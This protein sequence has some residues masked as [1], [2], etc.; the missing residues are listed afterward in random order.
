VLGN[1]GVGLSRFITVGIADDEVAAIGQ[2]PTGHGVLGEVIRSPQSLR[3]ARLVDHPTSS[4]FPAHHPP[5]M[6]FLGVPVRWAR[7]CS[8]TSI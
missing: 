5:M 4:G 7:P 2:R 6:S 1:D 3:L 8:G